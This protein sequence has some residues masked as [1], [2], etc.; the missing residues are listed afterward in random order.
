MRFGDDDAATDA[1]VA[2]VQEEGSCWMS[3]ST[4]R[5][6]RVMRISVCNW[7]TTIS[8]VDRSCAAILAAVA[9][10]LRSSI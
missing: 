4:W 8:D 5:G 7:A 9:A 10:E 6:R 2:V 3:P 1:V